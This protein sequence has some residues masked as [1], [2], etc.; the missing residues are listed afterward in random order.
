MKLVYWPLIG[1]L[2][3]LVQRGG[4]WWGGCPPRLLLDV[5]NVTTHPSTASIP[6]TVLLYNGS[7]IC[8]FNVA[9]KG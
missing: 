8:G 1:G 7:L 3:H 2:L 4:D 6:I 9:I 5:P